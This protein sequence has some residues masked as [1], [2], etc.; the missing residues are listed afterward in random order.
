MNIKLKLAATEHSWASIQHHEKRAQHTDDCAT[1][2][3]SALIRDQAHRFSPHDEGQDE[4]EDG[5][6]RLNGGGVGGVGVAE[7]KQEQQ[8]VA[9][10]ASEPEKEE[11][12]DEAPGERRRP[13]LRGRAAVLEEGE[14]REDGE[15]EE[16][17]EDAEDDA[18]DPDVERL[19]SDD[20][21]PGI[22]E[23]HAHQIGR[24]HV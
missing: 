11:G 15:R 23:L 7:A 1:D 5:N 6:G 3:G 24:A 18:V 12:A 9:K 14:R 22:N 10:D 16:V 8:L 21:V 20:V 2:L 4:G 13:R 17:P 19:L